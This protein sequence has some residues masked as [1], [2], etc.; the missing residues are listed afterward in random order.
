MFPGWIGCEK[1]V[2]LRASG[3][4]GVG[5]HRRG[6]AHRRQV[7]LQ[8]CWSGAAAGGAGIGGSFVFAAGACGF[9]WRLGQ[10]RQGLALRRR[11][12]LDRAGACCWVDCRRRLRRWV[13]SAQA[14]GAA[15]AGQ[16]Q[17]PCAKQAQA[18]APGRRGGRG[19]VG[20]H[21]VRPSLRSSLA[22]PL[23]SSLARSCWRPWRMAL[24]AAWRITLAIEPPESS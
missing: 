17:Q 3:S 13:F 23:R 15:Q 10:R 9:A 4:A 6:Q 19:G 12:W 24:K 18:A 14:S 20:V 7:Q 21:S 1:N 8:R 5:D 2:A 16:A 22:R 11:L